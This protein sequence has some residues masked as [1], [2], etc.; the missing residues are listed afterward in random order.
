MENKFEELLNS[1][2]ERGWRPFGRDTQ[3]ID[4]IRIERLD[5]MGCYQDMDYISFMRFDDRRQDWFTKY[6]CSI[7]DLVSKSSGLWQ[8]CVKNKIIKLWWKEKKWISPEHLRVFDWEYQYRLIES[9]LKD[10]SEIEQ[11]LL[12]NIKIDE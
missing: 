3:D 2:L 11:F 12:D 6:G 8:F 1:L 4:E 5:R 9:S 10:A 7:V